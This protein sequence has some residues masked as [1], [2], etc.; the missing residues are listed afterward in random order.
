[1]KI[2]TMAGMARAITTVLTILITQHITHGEDVI[3]TAV[4]ITIAGAIIMATDITMAE[5]LAAKNLEI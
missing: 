3:I 2:P 5:E 4:H 1:M